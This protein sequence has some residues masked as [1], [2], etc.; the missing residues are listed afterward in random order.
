MELVGTQVTV[1]GS[2]GH[3][4]LRYYGPI[5]GKAGVFG[6]I[7]LIG[8]LAS[9]RGKNSGDVDGVRYFDVKVPQTGLFIPWE[10]LRSSNP[11]LDSGTGG[12]ISRLSSGNGRQLL[13]AK[14]ST[15]STP[16]KTRDSRQETMFY[17]QQYE[18]LK[19]ESEKKSAILAE[20]QR[21][22]AELEPL[23]EE[24]E[25]DLQE[26]DKKLA[27]Q[28][29]EFERARENWRESMDLMSSTQQE[30]ELFYEEKL[31][32]LEGGPQVEELKKAHQKEV[33]ELQRK[34]EA[35][36][37]RAELLEKQLEAEKNEV[38]RKAL[39]DILTKMAHTSLNNHQNQLPIYEPKKHTDPST[40]RDNWCGLCEQDGHVALECPFEND[41]F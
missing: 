30:T 34:L 28:R 13:I 26:R 21:T 25:R 39:D 14:R 19:E 2:R 27:K 17:K 16:E 10:R 40:G 4:I 18:A 29:A 7:E 23:L 22:V 31:K 38:E 36:Q 15:Q 41:A 24:Y 12:R 35:S 3:G 1:P 32:E 20:L 6:G 8:P 5:D 11:Q 37:K 9:S 33:D